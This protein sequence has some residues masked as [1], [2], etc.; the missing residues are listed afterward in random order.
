M[1]AP[2]C[3]QSCR[4][5]VLIPGHCYFGIQ[6]DSPAE[7]VAFKKE[8]GVGL[9][10]W[11]L[12]VVILMALLVFNTFS[13]LF[14]PVVGQASCGTLVRPYD[15]YSQ[16]PEW[17]TADPQCP[18]FHDNGWIEVK[19]GIVVAAMLGFALIIEN[20]VSKSRLRSLP[21]P[22]HAALPPPPS[23]PDHFCEDC[24]GSVQAGAK[25]CAVCGSV[26]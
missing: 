14:S 16:R 25:F 20:A 6:A 9:K 11:R 21:P 4:R 3:P 12:Y 26:Q 7:V 23:I 22:P 10:N 5:Q 15:R 19:A 18:S 2:P 1:G 17:F 13:T 24:G 8:F